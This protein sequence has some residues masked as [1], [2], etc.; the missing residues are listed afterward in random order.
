[1]VY[2]FFVFSFMAVALK[3]ISQGHFL[4]FTFIMF[5][6]S[7]I[8]SFLVSP[9][10]FFKTFI[11]SLHLFH[12]LKTF[13]LSFSHGQWSWLRF[14]LWFWSFVIYSLIDQFFGLLFFCWVIFCFYENVLCHK[15]L[16]HVGCCT[17]IFLVCD[18]ECVCD[19][20]G[21]LTFQSKK[22]LKGGM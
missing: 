21:W 18:C 11:C 6:C 9:S 1:M 13:I 4:L 7:S 3:W 5:N 2:I 22:C 10:S 14:N 16:M 19:I 8:V 12:F 15:N 20:W 17:F